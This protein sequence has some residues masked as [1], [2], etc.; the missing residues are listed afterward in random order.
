MVEQNFK[1]LN[2]KRILSFFWIPSRIMAWR[3]IG[4]DNS[5]LIR[6]LEGKNSCSFVLN[7]EWRSA[8]VVEPR[9]TGSGIVLFIWNSLYRLGLFIL[10]SYIF[11][12]FIYF[13]PSFEIVYG[14]IKSTVV[15]EAMLATDRKHYCSGY[16]YVDAPQSIGNGV[17][18]SAPH[19]VRIENQ[20]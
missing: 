11:T 18:I 19:M 3:S 12:L 6:Q 16:P 1:K 7:K 9:W 2:F 20:W 10:E 4:N 15:K 14:V 13:F 5:D 17:T 8:E